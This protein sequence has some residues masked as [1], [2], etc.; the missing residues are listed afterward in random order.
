MAS[1]SNEQSAT[2]DAAAIGRFDQEISLDEVLRDCGDAESMNIE[3]SEGG[4]KIDDVDAKTDEPPPLPKK[5]SRHDSHLPAE[6]HDAGTVLESLQIGQGDEEISVHDLS[7]GEASVSASVKAF[8][9]TEDSVDASHEQVPSFSYDMNYKRRGCFIIFNHMKFKKRLQMNVRNG[10]NRDKRNLEKMAQNLGF[11]YIHSFD[12]LT[13]SEILDVVDKV[14]RSD[15]SHY[16][17]FAMAILTHGE[18]GDM[19]YAYDRTYHIDEVTEPFMANKCPTLAGKPKMFFIQACRGSKLDDGTSIT[20]KPIAFVTEKEVMVIPNAA[21][22]LLAFSTVPGYYAWRNQSEGSWFIQ[23]LCKCLNEFGDKLEIMQIMTRVNR[24][25]AYDFMS[26][27]KQSLYF[28][29]KKQIPS[30]VTRLTSEVYFRNKKQYSLPVPS[31][32]SQTGGVPRVD[33]AKAT[34]IQDALEELKE[35]NL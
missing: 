15:H 19:M 30:I 31:G 3:R 12:D 29:E 8:F 33:G 18:Q 10:T 13:H 34:D 32:K 22:F 35:T 5:G 26:Y 7:Q 2:Q 16:D 20:V 1:T 14:A 21:D 6:D 4:E 28:H 25:V 9:R 11:E 27:S 24:M 17:C 23:A